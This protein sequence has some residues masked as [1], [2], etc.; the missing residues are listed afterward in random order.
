MSK[1]YKVVDPSEPGTSDIE[2]SPIDWNKCVLC[3]T[4]TSESLSCPADS[5]RDTK[6]T[7]YKTTAENL[8]AFE[9]LGCLPRTINL[10]RLDEG[11]GIEASF[12]HHK[13]K[14][15]DTCRLKFNKTKLQ[16]AEKRKASPEDSLSS[17]VRK[18]FTRRSREEVPPGVHRCFFCDGDADA[19]ESLHKASTLELDAR[20]RK[21]ALELQD[22]PLLAKLSSGDMVAQDAE[23]HIKCLVALYNRA[24]ASS[25][26]QS[27][28][29]D[30]DVDAINHGVAFAELVSYMEE[31]RFDNLVAP[32]LKLSDLANLYSSRLEQ[33]GTKL[34]GAFTP[35]NSRIEYW[36]TFR[37]WKLTPKVVKSF[38]FSMKML[39]PH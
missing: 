27:C 13:A 36:L 21:C 9:K 11:E 30:C 23:Y 5:K 2:C 35:P 4:N 31:T 29:S 6:G 32:I 15:H 38:S 18:K 7:S 10:S 37:T 20:V 12:Q 19:G 16:R 17:D 1:V 22:K 24:R 8:L 28:S 14:W 39:V 25:V 26:V 33:L 34:Q 3:Q